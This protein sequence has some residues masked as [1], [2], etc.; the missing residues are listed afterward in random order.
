MVSALECPICN[1]IDTIDFLAHKVNRETYGWNDM[2]KEYEGDFSYIIKGCKHCK[3]MYRDQCFSDVD[4]DTLHATEISP[5]RRIPEYENYTDR[6][7]EFMEFVSQNSNLEFTQNMKI[8]DV[9]S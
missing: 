4:F 6:S 1:S 2:L 3:L 5:N 7:I 8:L 9:R